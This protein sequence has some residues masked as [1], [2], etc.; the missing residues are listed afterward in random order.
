MD[1]TGAEI[2]NNTIFV[3]SVGLLLHVCTVV[4]IWIKINRR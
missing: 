3:G 1:I 2:S 4:A